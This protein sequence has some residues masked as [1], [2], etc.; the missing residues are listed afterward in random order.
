M[1]LCVGSPCSI[2]ACA[3]FTPYQ[4]YTVRPHFKR[5]KKKGLAD[6]SCTWNTHHLDIVGNLRPVV[7]KPLIRRMRSPVAHEKYDIKICHGYA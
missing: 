5:L 6:P 7:L 4:G 2:P 3:R 1:L